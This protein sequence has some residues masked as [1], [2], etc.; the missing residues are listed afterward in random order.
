MSTLNQ[1]VYPETLIV[2]DVIR[3]SSLWPS[4]FQ[5][6]G[7]VMTGAWLLC[8]LYSYVQQMAL[9]LL[10]EPLHSQLSTDKRNTVLKTKSKS[11]HFH[12]FLVNLFERK[13]YLV[14]L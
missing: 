3:R 2:Y 8:P 12:W 5:P 10:P 6:G 7:G 9:I 14:I 1:F 4:G 11:V 13:S